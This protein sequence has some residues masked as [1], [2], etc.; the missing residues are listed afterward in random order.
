MGEAIRGA[1]VN[2]KAGTA[3]FIADV[4]TVKAKMR[5]FGQHGVTNVQATSAALRVLE[6]N[7]T[8]NLRAA[9][10]F[11]AETLH[12]GP[13]LQKVFAVTG[14]IAL[15]GVLSELEK[16]VAEFVRE[17]Q[18]A[19]EKIRGAFQSATAGIQLTNDELRVANDRLI[20]DIAKLQGQHQNTTTLAL[21]EMRVMADRLGQSLEKDL[22]AV[23][24]LLTENQIGRVS[25]RSLVVGEEQTQD[26]SE[27]IGGKTGF[28]GFTGEIAEKIAAGRAAIGSAKTPAQADQAAAQLSKVLQGAYD[29][30]IQ[31]FQ[32]QL[33]DAIAAS[34]PRTVPGTIYAP[35]RT[36]AGENTTARQELLRGL[37]EDLNEQRQEIPLTV[38]NAG[39]S[40]RND[41][42]QAGRQNTL[43]DKPFEDRMKAIGAAIDAAQAKL[44]AIGKPEAAQILAKAFGEAQ[45]AI[46][47]TNKALE[48]H[49]KTLTD[50]QTAQIRAKELTLAQTEADT[51]WQTKLAASSTAIAARVKSQQMLTA[52]IGAGYEATKQAN[53]ETRLMQELGQHYGDT[54]WMAAHAGDVA[55]LRAGFGREYDT[56][57]GAKTAESLQRLRDSIT[58]EQ[59]LARVQAAGAQAVRDATLAVKLRQI[60]RDN[61]AVS[62]KKLMAAE[63]EL[64]Q[65]E[66]ANAIAGQVAQVEQKTSATERLTAAIL[67]GAAAVRAATLANELAAIAREGDTAVPGVAGIGARGLAASAAAEADYQREL[68]TTAARADRVQTIDDEIG[69]LNDAKKVLGDT[70]GIEMAL[71]D[72]ENQRLQA[73]VQES[74]AMGKLSDGFRAFFIDM[75]QHA[76]TAAKIIYD[77]LHAALNDSSNLLAKMT[78]GKAPKGGWGQEWA[79]EFQGV[80]EQMTSSAIKSVAQRGL[81][82]LGKTLGVDIGAV[83]PDGTA[84]NPLWVKIVGAGVL[85]GVTPGLPA[86]GFASLDPNAASPGGSALSGMAKLTPFIFSAL[87]FGGYLAGGG[88]VM[89]GN[90]YMV[91]ENGPEPFVPASAGRVFPNG[92]LGGDTHLHFHTAIDARGS[93]MNPEEF[94]MILRQHE[95]RVTARAVQAVH[96]R[97]RRVPQR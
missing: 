82:A 93:R 30:Q 49:G 59:E 32:K 66:R 34:Q 36:I 73:L 37:L 63:I 41:E 62:A 77:S 70:L 18:Q 47:E 56:Q 55:N 31:S 40:R 65:N 10:R 91:G 17:I 71:R 35:A 19:P 80:G 7:M 46:E 79:K 50:A 48:R 61:D 87:K 43:A 58:L 38:Q 60:A 52:A 5:E 78:T 11:L 14:S 67:K 1:V 9:E 23:H 94:Q 13:A 95:Q 26:I 42:L 83:K 84:A 27:R 85:N 76:E 72:L 4:D 86:G 39:L 51:E 22:T 16:K 3:K 33:Q 44:A 96:E 69:K 45:K 8:N 75:Q 53:V 29:E 6:G 25:L 90:M 64:Y 20:D 28:G 74:L 92:S 54:A 57:Q 12:L 68:A 21:D 24:K 89:P 97:S 15:L 2:F 88:D 81:G